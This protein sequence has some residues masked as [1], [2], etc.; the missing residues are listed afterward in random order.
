MKPITRRH[1]LHTASALGLG[2]YGSDSVRSAATARRQG[3]IT[4]SFGTYGMQT[5]KLELAIRALAKIGY[6]GVEVMVAPNWDA[7]PANMSTHR[8]L[9][10]RKLLDSQGLKLT[11]LMENLHPSKEDVAHRAGLERLKQVVALGRAFAP[12]SRP[13]IQTVLGSGKWE[14]VRD[15]FLRRLTDWEELAEKEDALIAIKPHRG[16]GMSRPEEAI[17][18]IDQ[19][20]S[21]SRIRMVYDYSHYAFRNMTLEQTATTALPYTAHIAVKDTIQKGSATTFVLP[22]ES[23]NMDYDLLLSTFFQGGYREDVC[24][25]V[26]SAVWRQPGYD[27]LVS[28]VTC[29]RNMSTV[30]TRQQIPRPTDPT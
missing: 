14:Q 3:N 4:L 8:R 18:L 26:S 2:V 9:E 12:E 11:A 6:D 21:N 25:E 5:L 15:L 22:G 29:Y 16:G 17:W 27:P 23:G 1:F 10:I 13:L 24:C 7:T 30:F 20:G 19:L 28:A